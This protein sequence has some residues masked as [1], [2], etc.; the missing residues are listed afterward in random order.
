MKNPLFLKLSVGLLFLLLLIGGIVGYISMYTTG[1]FYDEANQKLNSKLAKFT[2]DEVKTFNDEGEINSEE[3]G[4]LMH[5][6]MAINPDVEVYLLDKEGTILKHV[7]LDKEKKVVRERVNMAPIEKFLASNGELHLDGDDPRSL[8]GQKIFSAAPIMRNGE[9]SAYY[10]IILESQETDAA[11]S[12]VVAKHVIS[13]GGKLILVCLFASLLIGLLYIWYLTKNL[14]PILT[15]ME[16]FREGNYSARISENTNDFNEVAKTYNKMANEIESNIT[17]IKSIDNFRKELIANISHDLKT[18]ISVIRGYAEMLI[19]KK[20]ELSDDEKMKY[21]NNINE[22]TKRVTGLMHQLLELSKLENNQIEL[23][24]E[25]FS[26]PEL[27]SDLMSRFELLLKEKNMQFEFDIEENLPLAFGDI[28]LV[29]RVIQNLVDNAIKYSPKDS[30]IKIGLNKKEDGIEFVITDEGRG[31]D[32][33][34]INKIFDRYTTSNEVNKLDKS[35][36]LGLAISKKILELHN[37]TIAVSSKLNIGT[38]F[39]FQL[40]T[41]SMAMA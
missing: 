34:N 41:Q 37:S 14:S 11:L 27:A 12:A 21:L 35:F 7:I 15:T 20:D 16:E 32:Q 38:T 8:D 13:I 9:V 18:P 4:K 33:K 22:S 2:V 30:K 25:P 5:S 29:E 1:C 23:R 39:S 3:I 17:K 19:L 36:G 6:M 24:E 10:Y 28:G 40:P 31:I 26:L